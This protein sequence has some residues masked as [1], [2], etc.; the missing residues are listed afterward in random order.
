MPAVRRPE[1]VKASASVGVRAV[2]GERAVAAHAVGRRGSSPVII[3][4]CAGS[5]SGHGREGALEERP[6]RGQARRCAA[7][8][9]A[10][11]P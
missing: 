9:P 2:E 7:C 8:A 11:S 1:A 4:A 6:P 5:V 10:A 3:D